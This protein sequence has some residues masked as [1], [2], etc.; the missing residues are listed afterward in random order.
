MKFFFGKSKSFFSTIS[1]NI[2]NLSLNFLEFF[3]RKISSLK[4]YKK[5][6]GKRLFNL[7]SMKSF[8]FLLMAK[9]PNQ[10]NYQ[11]GLCLWGMQLRYIL[12]SEHIQIF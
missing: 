3:P 10:L 7:S 9:S 5:I 4:L 12:L 11:N 1:I 8:T 6:L 2:K